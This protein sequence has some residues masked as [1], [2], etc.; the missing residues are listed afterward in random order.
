MFGW[1]KKKEKT[2]EEKKHDLKNKRDKLRVKIAE[3][4]AEVK[5]LWELEKYG[6]YVFGRRDELITLEKQLARRKVELELLEEELNG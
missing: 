1:F 3:E 4:M 5:T 6:G 2:P